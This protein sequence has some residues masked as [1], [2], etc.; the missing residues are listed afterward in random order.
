MSPSIV[1]ILKLCPFSLETLIAVSIFSTITVLPNKFKIICS[2]FL[3]YFIKSDAKPKTPW[4]LP[5]IFS[6]LFPWIFEIGKNDALPRLFFLK[7]SINLFASCSFSVTIFWRLAPNAISIAVSRFCGTSISSA[8]APFT[9]FPSSFVFSHSNSKAL[10]LLWYPSFSFSV[11]T[12]NLCFDSLKLNSCILL[13]IFISIDFICSSALF[14]SVI[15]S[16]SSLD[17]LFFSFWISKNPFSISSL[18]NLVLSNS[19]ILLCISFWSCTFL[20]SIFEIFAFCSFIFPSISYFK[21]VFSSSFL[22]SFSISNS[23]SDKVLFIFSNSLCFSSSSFS[24]F[25][26]FSFRLS[27]LLSLNFISSS[28][29]EIFAFVSSISSLNLFIFSSL[30]SILDFATLISEVKASTSFWLVNLKFWVFSISSVKSS[31][32]PFSSSLRIFIFS[33]LPSSKL[34]VFCII[35]M[36]SWTFTRSFLYFSILYKN[37]PTS[38]LLSSFFKSKYLFALSD[39]CF[40]GSK[41]ASISVKISFILK[42]FSLVCSNFFSDSSFLVLNFTIPAASSN[43]FLLSSDLLLNISSIFPWPIIEYPSFPIPVSINNSNMSFNLH[44]VL[45]M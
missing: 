26:L 41:L 8:N 20:F 34:Q 30:F 11:S 19:D 2:Y 18:E 15:I 22:L 12:K 44:C 13:F 42:T 37:K 17:T 28:V 24:Y 14:L 9:P 31:I 3:S 32:W 35:S 23:F 7:C 38:I 33:S 5:F 45:F 40:N 43:T 16:W 36:S 39:C 4:M 1:T 21:S 29:F 10:T 6:G 27:F 25:S